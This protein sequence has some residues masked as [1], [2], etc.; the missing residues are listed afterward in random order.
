MDK[1]QFSNTKAIVKVETGIVT[2]ISYQ[3][4]V[5]SGGLKKTRATQSVAYPLA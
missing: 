4:S 3:G 1:K 5:N 2:L